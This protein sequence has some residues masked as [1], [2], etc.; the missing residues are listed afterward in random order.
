MHAG[1]YGTLGA[2]LVQAEIYT[3]SVFGETFTAATWLSQNPLSQ[4]RAEFSMVVVPDGRV[5]AVGGYTAANG[6]A[7]TAMAEAYST[8]TNFWL[9]TGSMA[10]PRADLQAIAIY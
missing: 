4:A 8:T 2:P 7:P 6:N 10:S 3:P 9:P 1:G 5:V